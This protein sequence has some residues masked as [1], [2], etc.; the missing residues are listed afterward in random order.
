MVRKGGLEPPRVAPPDPK[1]GASANSAT[2]ARIYSEVYT[3]SFCEASSIEPSWRLRSFDS[4][5]PKPQGRSGFRLRAHARITAQLPF[6]SCFHF[7]P[8]RIQ[9]A[10]VDRIADPASPGEP[11][12]AQGAFLLGAQTKDGIAR[13]FV[14]RIGLQLHA[15]ASPD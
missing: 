14:Q 1:S 2:F 8:F 3:T 15:D 13:A 6:Q 7:G 9:N 4:P 5:S 10:E 12:F 11:V